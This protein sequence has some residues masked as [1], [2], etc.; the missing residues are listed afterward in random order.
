VKDIQ[1]SNFADADG[2]KYNSNSA[3]LSYSQPTHS[4]KERRSDAVQNGHDK[5]KGAALDTN[6]ELT[7]GNRLVIVEL[8]AGRG[9]STDKTEAP[10]GRDQS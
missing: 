4:T 1:K 2:H 9:A 8:I 3:K 6:A 5:H 7:G 10:H